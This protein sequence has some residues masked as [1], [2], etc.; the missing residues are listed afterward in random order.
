MGGCCASR[1]I[2]GE[3]VSLYQKVDGSIT[4]EKKRVNSQ[5]INSSTIIGEN[6]SKRSIDAN[7]L[8][9]PKIEFG[10][11]QE[12]T[13]CT[14][15]VDKEQSTMYIGT[16]ST[17][18]KLPELEKPTIN[19]TINV[20]SLPAKLNVC[21]DPMERP[22]LMRPENSARWTTGEIESAYD[23]M[24]KELD[25]L[26][27]HLHKVED[28][29]SDAE[30]TITRESSSCWRDVESDHKVRQDD[31]LQNEMTRA[32]PEVQI[33]NDRIDDEKNV[34]TIQQEVMVNPPS[35]IR[36]D[37]LEM[38]SNAR[39]ESE[40]ME[41][42]VTFTQLTHSLLNDAVEE[43]SNKRSGSVVDDDSE[44]DVKT[45]LEDT[46]ESSKAFVLTEETAEVPRN[47]ELD[48]S[49]SF[50]RSGLNQFWI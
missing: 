46:Q 10:C 13:E 17:A 27:D 1:P 24:E 18:K 32:S 40:Q 44:E 41:M 50:C 12:S 9:F 16:E 15:I 42:K 2:L 8:K 35:L 29:E 45:D 34:D 3:P 28:M 31:K 47:S 20:S 37:N 11:V 48:V 7:M 30:S 4:E 14:V 6:K 21:H 23:E 39:L 36:P 25:F 5:K 19:R 33:P 22:S 49:S 26:V 38:W 43:T